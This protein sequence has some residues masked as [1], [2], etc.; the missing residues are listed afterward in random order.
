MMI[1]ATIK[2]QHWNFHSNICSEIA[3]DAQD[4]IER[5][6][7]SQIKRKTA[8]NFYQNM[9]VCCWVTHMHVQGLPVGIEIKLA[10]MNISK[11]DA[12]RIFAKQDCSSEKLRS[13]KRAPRNRFIR[14]VVLVCCRE[15]IRSCCCFC[16]KRFF[17]ISFPILSA[18][19][20]VCGWMRESV[21][22]YPLRIK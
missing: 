5:T 13:Q 9:F 17:N 14:F 20:L 4:Q 11:K 19:H 22:S 3:N 18:Y 1:C 8:I 2:K 7:Y 10:I 6:Q 12:T 15:E 16:F 21:A